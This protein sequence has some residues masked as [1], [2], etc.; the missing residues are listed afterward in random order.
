VVSKCGFVISL[1]LG[2]ALSI[3]IVA[4]PS[5][6]QSSGEN[7]EWSRVVAD[8]KKEGKV[9]FYYDM[10]T[11][12]GLRIINGFNK[13]YPDIKVEPYRQPG[14]ALTTRIDQERITGADGADVIFTSSIFWVEA[15]GKEGALLKP[16]AIAISRW[17][18]RF[19]RPGGVYVGSVEPSV[20]VY[21]KDQVS[22]P[23]SSYV[24]LLAPEY[25]NRI[26]TVGLVAPV[27]IAHYDWAEKTFGADYLSRLNAQN[28]KF[29]TGGPA[30]AQAVASGEIAVSGLQVVPSAVGPLIAA[31]AHIAYVV[32]SPDIGMG[33][34]MGALSW[35]KHPNA[36]RLFLDY[37]MSPEGQTDWNGA[38]ESA[39]PL[40]GIPGSLDESKVAAQWDPDAY[41]PNVVEAYKAHFSS[42]FGERGR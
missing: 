11:P 23:P 18:T 26:G 39:S 14:G 41:P 6:A 17:P 8:A 36:A 38:G 33:F 35:S 2:M 40:P 32:P 22:K 34:G 5:F 37:A 12:V 7:S 27:V 42:V 30:A 25:K 4:T 28:P 3:G 29:Y 16:S 10:I 15:R 1:L 20:L 21:N 9:T 13:R 31:G 19:V 24:D